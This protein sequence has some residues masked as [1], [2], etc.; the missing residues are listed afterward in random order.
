MRLSARASPARRAFALAADV[1]CQK[2]AAQLFEPGRRIEEHVEDRHAVGDGERDGRLVRGD[3]SFQRVGRVGV[4]V[5]AKQA[6]E[7]K[8]ER[9]ADGYPSEKQQQEPSWPLAIRASL[10]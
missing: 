2:H 1:V 8:D 5:A 9:F 3:R 10:R 7:L 4:V 6:C